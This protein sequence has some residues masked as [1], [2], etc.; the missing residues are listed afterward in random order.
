MPASPPPPE[1]VIPQPQPQGPPVL[2]LN[3]DVFLPAKPAPAY[4][5]SQYYN[6]ADLGPFSLGGN[7]WA[8]T[9]DTPGRYEYFCVFHRKQGI[10]GS[11]TVTVP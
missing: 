5:A 4:D 1:F 2:V 10:K 11:V 8:L 7:S 6:S 3:P 9:F